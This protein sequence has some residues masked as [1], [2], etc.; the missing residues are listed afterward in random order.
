VR[1]KP[2]LSKMSGLEVLGAV[3]AAIQLADAG[4]AIVKFLS[5]LCSTLHDA[6]EYFKKQSIQI[7]H[8]IEV[9]RLIQQN[10]SL[11]TTLISSLLMNCNEK[12]K[13]LEGILG[14]ATAKLNAGKVERYWK[15]LGG[16]M[17]GSRISELCKSL[18]E[19]KSALILCI[20]SINS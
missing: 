11:Q 19:E 1:E 6:P 10:P 4:L 9:A 3:S 5:I 12:A 8:L 7:Q 15:T 17:K 2:N 18:E 16:V 20:A 14:K 13:E